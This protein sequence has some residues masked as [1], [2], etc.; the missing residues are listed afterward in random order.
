M[1]TAAVFA[2]LALAACASAPEHMGSGPASFVPAAGAPAP[3]QAR[4]YADC[5]AQATATGR[6]DRADTTLRFT[7]DGA[8][9]QA[10]YDGLAAWSAQIGSETVA[11]GRTFRS[12]QNVQR[13]LSGLD[14]CRRAPAGNPEYGCTIV[15]NVG[16][17]LDATR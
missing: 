13:D 14:Y 15:L 7:C 2:A 16:D 9:A 11:D 12:T 17:F 8:P 10:F 6:F 5:I 4:F 3:P 1:R